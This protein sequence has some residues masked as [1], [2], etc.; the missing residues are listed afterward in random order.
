MGESTMWSHDTKVKLIKIYWQMPLIVG[1]FSTMLIVV[2][3][4][5]C[6]NRC[7]LLVFVENR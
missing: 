5:N 1:I 3:S 4:C 2:H 6:K 7:K